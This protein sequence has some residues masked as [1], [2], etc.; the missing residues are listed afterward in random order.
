MRTPQ[1]DWVYDS[2]GGAGLENRDFGPPTCS[3]GSLCAMLGGG[4]TS[5]NVLQSR[6]CGRVM[7]PSKLAACCGPR[8]RD[9]RRPSAFGVFTAIRDDRM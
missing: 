8:R 6:C 2:V 3:E 1:L 4:S 5:A 9:Q 7:K